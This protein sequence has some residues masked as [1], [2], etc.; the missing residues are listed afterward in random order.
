[1]LDGMCEMLS[2]KFVPS[3]IRAV[4]ARCTN[5]NLETVSLGHV[6]LEDQKLLKVL[7]CTIDQSVGKKAFTE[8]NR[9][10][11]R[12]VDEGTKLPLPLPPSPA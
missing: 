5:P 7:D 4:D 2:D 12:R 10:R 6:P 1:M 3:L 9:R 11:L 8:Q